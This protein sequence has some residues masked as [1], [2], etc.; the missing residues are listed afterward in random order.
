VSRWGIPAAA[1]I[2]TIVTACG[3]SS[4]APAPSA[5]PSPSPSPRTLTG[6]V[7]LV[8]NAKEMA[9]AFFSNG[10][11]PVFTLAEIS[12]ISKDGVPCESAGGYSDLT[13]GRQVAIYGPKA[14]VLATVPLGAGTHHVLEL[15]EPSL[16]PGAS[17]DVVA[18]AGAM[19]VQDNQLCTFAFEALGIPQVETLSVEVGTRG[20]LTYTNAQLEASGWHIELRLPNP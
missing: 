13:A 11:D 16:I 4:T 19:A 9:G 1:L 7:T 18:Y 2:A 3:S 12:D 17:I 15:D 20:R 10:T 14:D 5:T 6:S 8:Q